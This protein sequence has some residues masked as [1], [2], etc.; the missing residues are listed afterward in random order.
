MIPTIAAAGP[1]PEF[2][3]VLRRARESGVGGLEVSS[4]TLGSPSGVLG[5]ELFDRDLVEGLR[6]RG[7]NVSRGCWSL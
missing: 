6:E 4:V 5:S 1:K 2:E 7:I 3:R